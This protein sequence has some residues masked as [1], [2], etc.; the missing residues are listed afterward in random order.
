MKVLGQNV[1]KTSN[2]YLLNDLKR[3]A[4]QEIEI[5][6]A[7]ENDGITNLETGIEFKE[8]ATSKSPK[9]EFLIF[10]RIN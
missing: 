7:I 8:Y 2:S 9:T 10:K 4:A 6:V 1:D 3:R 5:L